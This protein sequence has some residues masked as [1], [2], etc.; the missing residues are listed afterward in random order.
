MP[1]KSGWEIS[2]DRVDKFDKIRSMY[3]IGDPIITSKCKRS[4]GDGFLVVTDRGFAWRIHAGFSTG[5]TAMGNNM[6]INWDDLYEIIPKKP[7]L[8]LVQVKKRNMKTKELVL[9]KNGD[10]NFKKWKLLIY[11][12]KNEP[13]DHLKARKQDFNSLFTQ[14]WEA[15][16][17]SEDPYTTDSNY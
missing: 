8:I 13:K 6:W 4:G 7:G 1:I 17:S 12:N 16:R 15:H 5:V 3:N 14:I 10:Y 2:Q 9:K 11:R